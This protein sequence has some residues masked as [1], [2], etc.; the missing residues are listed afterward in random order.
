M[1]QNEAERNVLKN[2]AALTLKPA[3]T[4]LNVDEDDAG[5]PDEVAASYGDLPPP[6]YGVCASL[7]AEI[8]SLPPDE[9]E[10]FLAEMGLDRLHTPGL[11]A[12]VHEALGR[13]TFYTTGE[14][15]VAARSLPLGATAVEAAGSV[16]T[17]M[18]HGFIR[19][20]VV[21]FD[22]LKAAGDVKQAKADGHVRL[23]GRDYRVRDG[24]IILFHFSR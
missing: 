22:D 12:A 14:K 18:A 17:D 11:P 8:R 9:Q 13:I 2:F 24:D 5:R 15:E 3:L 20:E 1:P 6:A 4:V 7:E 16:H 19:A 10:T 23:E 21:S